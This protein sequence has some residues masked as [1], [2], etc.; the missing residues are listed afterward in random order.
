MTALHLLK[1][2]FLNFRWRPLTEDVQQD[3]QHQQHCPGTEDC[4]AAEN[5]SLHRKNK[6]KSLDWVRC[7]PHHLPLLSWGQA[8]F[9]RRQC[10]IIQPGA[11]IFS[12]QAEFPSLNFLFYIAWASQR[13]WSEAVCLDRKPKTRDRI[14]WGL[15]SPGHTWPSLL[16]L[17]SSWG[18]GFQVDFI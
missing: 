6:G 15:A 18:Q 8:M 12:E 9:L 5:G 13:V 3:S 10:H 14:S 4:A 16:A 7:A 11:M 17:C 1:K 2:V